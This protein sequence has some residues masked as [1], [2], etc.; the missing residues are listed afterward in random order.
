MS[1]LLCLFCAARH[2]QKACSALCGGVPAHRGLRRSETRRREEQRVVGAM[3]G[4]PG[5]ATITATHLCTL[6]FRASVCSLF[7]FLPLTAASSREISRQ[8]TSL[9][10][11]S[12]SESMSAVF[13]TK[14][15]ALRMQLQTTQFSTNN[16]SSHFEKRREHSNKQGC[17]GQ[18]QPSRSVL[19]IPWEPLPWQICLCSR[20][21]HA[22]SACTGGTAISKDQSFVR[23]FAELFVGRENDAIEKCPRT[24]FE[25]S[26]HR[27]RERLLIFIHG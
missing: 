15:H 4:I 17:H 25:L 3:T 14:V 23:N 24:S 5:T 26:M 16:M 10:A 21:S 6:L 2:V 12:V 20:R 19:P 1:I 7:L 18:V 9:I 11:G 8:P 22:M 13:S 27:C